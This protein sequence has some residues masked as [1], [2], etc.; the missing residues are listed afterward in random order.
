MNSSPDSDPTQPVT[1]KS[2]LTV[3]NLAKVLAPACPGCGITLSGYQ[4]W[5]LVDN[6]PSDQWHQFVKEHPDL[7]KRKCP[8]CSA[9]NKPSPAMSSEQGA[10]VS[11]GTRFLLWA[12]SLVATIVLIALGKSIAY[13]LP[14]DFPIYLVFV[15]LPSWGFIPA[16]MLIMNAGSRHKD[17]GVVKLGST[18][19]GISICLAVL[20]VLF[21]GFASLAAGTFPWTIFNALR[22]DYVRSGWNLVLWGLTIMIF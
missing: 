12:G 20:G 17:A 19:V 10:S 22:E 4:L 13:A 7:I 5:L 8:T 21:G 2:K 6:V 15:L 14:P 18:L 9:K 1:G 11:G 3:E 16:S